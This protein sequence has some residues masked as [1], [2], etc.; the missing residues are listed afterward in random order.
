MAYL[1]KV[2]PAGWRRAKPDGHISFLCGMGL[3]H[4]K[5]GGRAFQMCSCQYYGCIHL[6]GAVCGSVMIC[7]LFATPPSCCLSLDTGLQGLEVVDPGFQCSNSAKWNGE[8]V[9]AGYFAA[10]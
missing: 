7:S 3:F 5:F 9:S 10:E 1:S 4:G 8:I 2:G 6:G